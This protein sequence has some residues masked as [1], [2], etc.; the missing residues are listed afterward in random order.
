MIKL[1]KP[2]L[3][4]SG[5][6]VLLV[7]GVV[8]F[9]AKR[10]RAPSPTEILK[11]EGPKIV[12]V[13]PEDGSEEVSVTTPIEIVF[14]ET[15]KEDSLEYSIEPSVE[16]VKTANENLLTIF[17]SPL[18]AFEPGMQYTVTV[19]AGSSIYSFSFKTSEQLTAGDEIALQ[20]EYDS[21]FN[22]AA[23]EYERTHPLL[24]LMPVEK[25]LFKI[26]YKGKGLYEYTLKGTNKRQAIETMLAW[27]KENGVNP[28]NLN[29]KEYGS[30]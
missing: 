22:K 4:I 21:S 17:L 23:D 19:T 20:T 13:S 9:T 24:E 1:S 8:I 14:D 5:A 10:D 11:E 15:V 30:D 7:L 6:V 3:L 12:K 2:I 28:D 27:W 16:I 25:D 18:P 26:E 29:L